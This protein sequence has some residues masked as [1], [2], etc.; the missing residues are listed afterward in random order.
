MN[1]RTSHKDVKSYGFNLISVDYAK[2][3][4]G[5]AF[6]GGNSPQPEP[7]TGSGRG[8]KH[9]SDSNSALF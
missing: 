6:I 3:E 1:T 9:R 5:G 2:W 4:G 8:C 7:S